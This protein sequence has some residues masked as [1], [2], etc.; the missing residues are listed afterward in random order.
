MSLRNALT[1]GRELPMPPPDAPT[2]F[3]LADA[4]RVRTI[5]GSAGFHGVELEPIDEPIDL[6]ADAVGAFDFAKTIGE[7]VNV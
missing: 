6:V 4:E 5:L 3:S 7:H 2:P 1:M